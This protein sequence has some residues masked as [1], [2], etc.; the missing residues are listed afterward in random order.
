MKKLFLIISI[1]ILTVTLSAKEFVI[2]S[3]SLKLDQVRSRL[4]SVYSDYYYETEASD[5]L[6]KMDNLEYR[7]HPVNRVYFTSDE[8]SQYCYFITLE[9]MVTNNWTDFI[10]TLLWDYG[11]NKYSAN[12]DLIFAGTDYGEYTIYF[13]FQEIITDSG[14]KYKNVL[15]S[16]IYN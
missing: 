1:F 2:P 3:F 10:L 14:V 5:V 13:S 9:N 8:L 15:I 6:I 4:D 16:K 7:G 11:V 12:G